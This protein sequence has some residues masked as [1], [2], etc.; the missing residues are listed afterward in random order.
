MEIAIIIGF[1]LFLVCI[2]LAFKF[3]KNILLAIG[4]VFLFTIFFVGGIAAFTYSE[5]KEMQA[6]GLTS[7]NQL[8]L[9]DDDEVITGV[10]I[11]PAKK[12]SPLDNLKPLSEQTVDELSTLY[13]NKEKKQMLKVTKLSEFYTPEEI[14]MEQYKEEV[15]KIVFIEM[16]VL[17]NSPLDSFKFS[18]VLGE[19]AAIADALGEFSR[20]DIIELLSSEDEWEF[21]T[22]HVMENFDFS[23]SAV[24]NLVS[25]DDLPT[26]MSIEDLADIEDITL[27]GEQKLSIVEEQVISMLRSVLLDMF[28]TDD[29]K[30]VMFVL[31]VGAIAGSDEVDGITYLFKEYK[32]KRIDI[33]PSSI[34]FDIIRLSPDS[35]IDKVKSEAKLG[36]GEVTQ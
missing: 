36:I 32:Q 1:V 24:S 20:G 13:Q 35:L 12:F 19:D 6:Y 28:G 9:V 27:S 23:G 29:L 4:A 14:E 21:M 25:E 2:F 10:T 26:G 31:N 5:V 34:I 8:L 7:A 3:I 11:L 16:D 33:Y 30:L 17:E 22:E 15:Y 18:D